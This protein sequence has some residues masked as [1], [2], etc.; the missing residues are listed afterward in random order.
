LI[1]SDAFTTSL[2]NAG[3]S[4]LSESQSTNAEFGELQKSGIICDGADNNGDFAFP[5]SLSEAHE[6]GQRQ[7]RSVHPAHAQPLQHNTVE[8]R[9][10]PASQ[11]SVEPDK[12]EKVGILA[13]GVCSGSPDLRMFSANVDTLGKGE[14]KLRAP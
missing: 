14:E 9:S 4:I 10:G 6:F 13:L 1:E 8:G 3:T 5:L 2:H 7:R 11:E 12:Q